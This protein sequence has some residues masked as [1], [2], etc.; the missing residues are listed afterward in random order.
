MSG[1]IEGGWRIVE[2]CESEEAAGAFY[3]SELFQ[4]MVRSTGIAPPNITSYPV[5]SVKK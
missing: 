1:P 2:V 3:G 4:Q 5:E